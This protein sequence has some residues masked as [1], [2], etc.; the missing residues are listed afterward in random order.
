[1]SLESLQVQYVR[2]INTELKDVRMESWPILFTRA[3]ALAHTTERKDDEVIYVSHQLIKNALPLLNMNDDVREEVVRVLQTCSQVLLSSLT[4]Q[5]T[6]VKV[7]IP[8]DFKDDLTNQVYAQVL[9]S[10]NMKLL[11]KMA[12]VVSCAETSHFLKQMRPQISEKRQCAI[13]S[14]IYSFLLRQHHIYANDKSSREALSSLLKELYSSHFDI[15][16][17]VAKSSCRCVVM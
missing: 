15:H 9:T 3:L 5:R 8:H 12:W 14:T 11:N 6:E 10:Q 2:E 1:M 16:N 17:D 7:A 4:P 13:L